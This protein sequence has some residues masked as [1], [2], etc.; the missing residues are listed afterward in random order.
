MHNRAGISSS[1]TAVTTSEVIADESE[2]GEESDNEK[3]RERE[4]LRQEKRRNREREFRL[5]KMGAEKRAKYIARL[6]I[7]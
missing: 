7:V 3:A 2:S 1:S 6:V 5:S 4:E